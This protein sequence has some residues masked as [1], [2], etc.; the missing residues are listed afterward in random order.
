MHTTILSRHH[1]THG[2]RASSLNVLCDSSDA[3]EGEVTDVWAPE[4]SE[5]LVR[6]VTAGADGRVKYW[7][8]RP[9]QNSNSGKRSA[10]DAIPGSITC[11]FT[12]S[13]TDAPFFNRSDAVKRRQT[14]A[15]DAVILARCD[16]GAN[17]VCGVTEDGDLQVWFDADDADR[18]DVRLDVGSKDEFG[19]VERLELDVQKES[20]GPNVSILVHHSC[21]PTYTRYDLTHPVVGEPVPTTRTFTTISCGAIT[22]LQA[23]LLDTPP[24]SV[25]PNPLPALSARISISGEHPAF[26][27]PPPLD[28]SISPR[29]HNHFGRFVVGGDQ[30]GSVYVWA[31]DGKDEVIKPIRSWSAMSGKI[32]AID[33][34]CGLV[35]VGR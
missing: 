34:S 31:W 3:H 9:G 29:V 33:V 15:P 27:P 23:Y 35:A 20:E 12:S 1:A 10:T 11:L 28:L 26:L 21:A 25:S 4:L 6:W 8:L 13:P 17:V 5:A 22:S 2:G 32:T 19:G 16:V 30:D 24:I 18:R 7:Q 14:G